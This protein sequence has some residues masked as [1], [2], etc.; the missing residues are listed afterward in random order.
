MSFSLIDSL[1]GQIDYSIALT[2][3]FSPSHLPNELR[4]RRPSAILYGYPMAMAGLSFKI[5]GTI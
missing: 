5:N 1:R 3:S 2:P 4:G